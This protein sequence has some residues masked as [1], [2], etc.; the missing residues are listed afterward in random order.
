MKLSLFEN[1]LSQIRLLGKRD[2]RA[3][4]FYS[5]VTCLN[6]VKLLREVTESLTYCLFCSLDLTE[7]HI[8]TCSE[9]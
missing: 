1:F 5:I 3:S 2:D 4:L 6:E 7:I 8:M 9:I